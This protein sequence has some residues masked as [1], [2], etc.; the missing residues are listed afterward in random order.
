[1]ASQLKGFETLTEG[2]HQ[3]PSGSL[4]SFSH[5][6]ASTHHPNSPILL[7]L[8]GWPQDRYIWRYAI[9][10][11]SSLGYTLFVPDLPGYGHS[12][13]PTAPSATKHDRIT[14]GTSLLSAVRSVYPDSPES[15]IVLIAHDRGAR[16]AQRFAMDDPE[17]NRIRGV[18]LLDIVP[19]AAQWDAAAQNP[20]NMTAYFHWAF[21]PA[22]AISIPLIRTYGG[23]KFCRDILLKTVGDNAKGRESFFADGAVEHYSELYQQDKVNEGAALDYKAGS[24]EYWEREVEDRRLGRKVGV[25]TWVVYSERNLRAMHDVPKVWKEWVEQGMLELHGIGEGVGHY[26]PEEAPG[27]VNRYIEEFLKGLGL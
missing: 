17:S 24:E 11:L 6:P 2:T 20:R 22:M 1:M 16:V 15:D 27:E 9:P 21:L 10:P 3:S 23:G 25:R 13:L 18:L 19:Y 8:H 26:L 12:T 14:V 5:T 4:I 7:L